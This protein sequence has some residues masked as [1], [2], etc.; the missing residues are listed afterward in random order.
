MPIV[1]ESAV[2]RRAI[3]SL[4]RLRLD[5]TVALRALRRTPAFTAAMIAVLG[6]GIGVSTAMFTVY[7]TV[8][9]EQLPVL[10]QD[11]LVVMHP[12]D[13]GG[14]HLDVPY[15]Y[16]PTIAGDSALFRGVAGVY[17]LDALPTPFVDGDHSIDLSAAS[18]SPNY[19]DVLGARPALGR[20]FRPED[21][22]V[23]AAPVIVLSYAAWHR[24]FDG[25]ATIVG[26]T[27]VMPYTEKRARIVGVAPAGFEYPAGT[28]AWVTLPSDFAAQ[29][30][31]IARLAPHATIAAA[32][33][34]LF[35]LTQRANPFASVPAAPGAAPRFIPISAVEASSL[36]DTVL[37]SARP[38]IEALAVAVA[39]L[40][41]IACV[42]AGNLMLVR[43]LGRGREI[44]V[45]RAIGASYGDVTRLFLVENALLG[46]AGGL[47][48][49]VVGVALL[50]LVH[51]AAPP[52]LPRNDAL[53]LTAAPVG[54]AAVVTVAT[55][56]L[57]GL[58]PSLL[59]SRVSSYTA[60]RADARSGTGSRSSRRTARWLVASQMALALIL[61]A[62]AALLVRTFQRLASMDLGYAPDHLS[63]I[64][65]TGPESDLSSAA[66][67]HAV[68]EQV[69]T[70]VE[71]TP[72]V[73]AA[74]PV[75]SPPLRGRSFYIMKVAPSTVSAAD[76]DRYPFVPF[77]FVGADYFR[78]F[79]IPIRRGR[80][81]RPSDVKGAPNVVVVSATLAHQLWPAEDA[82]GKQLVQTGDNS[83][84]T[85][86]GVANDTHLRELRNTGPVVY[87]A[88]EQIDD[89]W[90]GYLAVRT[91][92]S[93]PATL[94]ALRA[95]AR[96]VDHSLVLWQ[97]ETMDQLLGE[98]MAQ[99][100]LSALLLSSIGFFALLLSA[101]GLYGVMSGTVR[102]QTR[103]IGVRIAVGATPR[104][105][106]SLVLGEAM[107][108]VGAGA[109]AGAVGVLVAGRLLS[110][111]LFGV[112]PFDPISLG[113]AAAVLLSVGAAAAML[114]A[115]RAA[116]IDPMEA[117]RAE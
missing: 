69:V 117:L 44:A 68:A 7:K 92:G 102:Q 58:A 96:D 100:R 109:I 6:L 56:L 73:I 12:L 52:Q 110:S 86:V 116:R 61:V 111:Q 70:R 106:R 79:L 60:L 21:G 53:G 25:D 23:G 37:G 15:P 77:E 4:D 108:V 71:A 105:V 81:F 11:R 8:L 74:T 41:L 94:P 10:A 83:V 19:F 1:R 14:T 18:A 45:R 67:I 47:A 57:F 29:V 43:L 26:R 22:A 95:A 84:W 91:T 34:G 5:V 98:P 55:L 62:S 107:R 30:D 78:T 99:P 51:V 113:V 87:F 85:V 13:R 54:L 32:R 112:S 42:N 38:V 31:V 35:A 103:A 88:W 40:L 36:A 9:V 97:A 17:H 89:S 33:S 114:P 16:L 80:G 104:D 28:D 2:V 24:R 76:R 46:A 72:G 63:L 66:R 39:L 90:S 64:A 82:I 50:R 93:L 48:G 27:L 49:L 65:F 75:E 115:W 3:E 101:I 20:L 59:A